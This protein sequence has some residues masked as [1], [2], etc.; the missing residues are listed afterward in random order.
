MS[1]RMKMT[2]EHTLSI[3]LTLSTSTEWLRSSC[4]VRL[5]LNFLG[6][7]LR[8]SRQL[9]FSTVRKSMQMNVGECEQ[10]V[11]LHFNVGL[12]MFYPT[13]TPR[14]Y[15]A[16]DVHLNSR[17]G[18]YGVHIPPTLHCLVVC[19]PSPPFPCYHTADDIST[20]FCFSN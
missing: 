20:G 9:V 13:Y 14:G 4:V 5:E 15:H 16:D 8:V 17:S 7:I 2:S 11:L 12:V 6:T 3:F 19:P 18:P 1:K 10:R